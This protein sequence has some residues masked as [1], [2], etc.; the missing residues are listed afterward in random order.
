MTS[1]KATKKNIKG[2]NR[3]RQKRQSQCGKVVNMPGKVAHNNNRK[4]NVPHLMA[5]D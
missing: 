3:S 4:R 5:Q 1:I 2:G